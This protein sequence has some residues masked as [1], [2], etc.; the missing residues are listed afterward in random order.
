MGDSLKPWE[1]WKE[2]TQIVVTHFPD[3][4]LEADEIILRFVVVE[5][6]NSM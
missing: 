6:E 5:N 4:V 1:L 3:C 2:K